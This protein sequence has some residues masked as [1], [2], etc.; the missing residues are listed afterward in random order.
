MADYAK[1]LARGAI[2]QGLGM[3][4]G[5]EAEA[6]L[7]ERMGEGSYEQNLAKIRGE[8]GQFSREYP[9]T[10]T[11]TEFAGGAL[12]AVGLMMVPGGQ[13]AAVRQ[14][15]GALARLAAQGAAQGAVAGA[16][17][18]DQDRASGA[19]SG[20][21]VGGALGAAIPMAMRGAGAAGQ[22]LR[23]RLLPTES[24]VNQRAAEKMTKALGETGL[25]PQQIEAKMAQDRSM[26]VPSV[27]ANV[28]HGATDL[29]EVVAQRAGAGAR[30]IEETLGQQKAGSRERVYSKVQKELNP[31]HYYEDLE[32]LRKEMSERAGPLYKQ[33]Y[34]YGE[35]TDPEVLKFLQ[36]PQFKQAALEA[37]KLLDAE[38]RKLPST[39]QATLS[40]GESGLGVDITKT[41][42]PTVEY[43]DQVKRGLD[44]LIEKE[45]DP[46]TGKMT[47]LGRVYVGKKGE[48][49]QALDKAVPDYEVARGVYAGGAELADAMRKGLNE[50]N[51]LD[52]E[53]VLKTVSGM[54]QAEKEAY[55]TGVARNLYSRIMDPS[56]NF[57]AAQRIIGAPETQA[58]L[59]PLF[60]NPGQF[61]LFK[62]ALEREAQ[63]F[64]ESNRILGGSQTGK[65]TQMREAFEASDGVGEAVGHAVTGGFGSALTSLV[66]K[67]V[68]TSQMPE[69][70]ANKLA[71]M[72]MA[73]DPHEVAAVV[74][75]L[76]EHAAQAAPKAY[77]AGVREAGTIGGTTGAIFPAPQ[78]APE[79]L[80]K[81]IEKAPSS[82]VEYDIEKATQGL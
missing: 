41:E 16:G 78:G 37:R 24:V 1:N 30:K 33:A 26:Q 62:A 6:W 69:K 28:G 46:V 53:Q 61:N 50:F 79:T 22:W 34:S 40:R 9:T 11:A 55:R 51:K 82:P 70:T 47:S 27:I 45:T 74:K 60:D 71:D 68:R 23:E 5:D 35:V 58:K 64:N 56:N 21:I 25:T 77:Q 76:E 4:W 43:L 39:T 36:L 63:L 73:K 75:M 20:A 48:F 57:N 15:A 38:G 8:Y 17:S 10:S 2:G 14:G 54:S 49:L 80:E 42:K 32:N 44:A 59:Q 65:R 12:P 31:G 81:D 19:A 29:A 66:N 52:H 7:R 3:G 18:A 72:L 13:P 67:V